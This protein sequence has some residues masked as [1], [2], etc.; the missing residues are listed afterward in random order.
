MPKLKDEF[1]QVFE[2]ELGHQIRL[3]LWL[4]YQKEIVR[5]GFKVT[6]D[7]VRKYARFK[8]LSPRKQVSLAVKEDFLSFT[9]KYGEK[10]EF[11]G[12]ELIDIIC[13]YRPVL[14][15]DLHAIRKQPYFVE[16]ACQMSKVYSF[17]D[18]CKVIAACLLY[19]RKNH[20]TR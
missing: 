10:S 14:R 15:S 20:E 1:R 16:L 19:Q 2:Y 12:V 8:K 13:S 18:A 4:K 3:S 9:R 5:A 7:N 6:K 11:V 17:D